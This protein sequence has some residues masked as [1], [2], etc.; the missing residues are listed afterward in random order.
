MSAVDSLT[1]E[2]LELAKQN[3][4]ATEAWT[5]KLQHF[6]TLLDQLTSISSSTEIKQQ[7]QLAAIVLIDE[8]VELASV[9]KRARHVSNLL[10]EEVKTMGVE[11]YETPA[12]VKL[13][14]A[15]SIQVQ[16]PAEEAQ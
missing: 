5:A 11:D 10:L 3:T 8:G 4:A 12:G 13:T 14:L 7:V 1:N 9:R 6:Q 16:F 2:V 15:R